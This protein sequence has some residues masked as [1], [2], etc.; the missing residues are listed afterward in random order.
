MEEDRR[1]F[2]CRLDALGIRYK[3]LY[4]GVDRTFCLNLSGTIITDLSPLRAL[5]L[6]HLCLQGCFK[7]ADFSPLGDMSL[8]WLNLC[9]TRVT[10]LSPLGNP[11]GIF[12][13]IPLCSVREADV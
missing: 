1:R 2:Q 12:A 6:T 11:P 8:T 3:S 10:D 4:V 9:R 5:P 13:Q 7:I